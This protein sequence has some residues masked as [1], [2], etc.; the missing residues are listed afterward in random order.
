MNMLDIDTMAIIGLKVRHMSRSVQSI[1]A[2]TGIEILQPELASYA[3]VVG[4]EAEAS[5]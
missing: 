4:G 5:V 3:L 2:E 1:L